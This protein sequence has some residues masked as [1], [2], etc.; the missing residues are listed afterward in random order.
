[1]GVSFVVI[2]VLLGRVIRAFPHLLPNRLPGLAVHELGPGLALALAIGAA[3]V[4]TGDSRTRATT[5][6]ACF[7]LTA[8]LAGVA[9]LAWEFASALR[10]QWL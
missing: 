6:L 8:A 1:M 7:A 4:I 3:M 5:R 2:A 10:G 9:V